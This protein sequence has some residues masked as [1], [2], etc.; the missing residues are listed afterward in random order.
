MPELRP[1][2]SLPSS[3]TAKFKLLFNTRGKGWAGSSPI[4]VKIGIN[5]LKKK[6]R[7]QSRCASFQLVRRRKWMFSSANFGS[8]ISLRILYWWATNICAS[9]LIFAYTCLGKSPSGPVCWL[10]YLIWSLMPAT[11]TSKNSSILLLK[12]QRNL[13]RSNKGT[14]SSSA[15]ASTRL[16]KANKPNS[17]LTKYSGFNLITRDK[18]I[19]DCNCL[20]WRFYDKKWFALMA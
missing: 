16:L 18:I 3:S 8:T 17:R 19:L 1:K 5:S 15:W 2:A 4:G 9:A 6:S 14:R 20:P 11:R 7:I 10:L 13:S 12:I